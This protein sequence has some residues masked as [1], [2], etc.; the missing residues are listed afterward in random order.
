M[1]K[2]TK[3]APAKPVR[4]VTRKL[5]AERAAVRS[6]AKGGHI[7]ATRY[8]RDPE[9]VTVRLREKVATLLS[10]TSNC[11]VRAER[12]GVPDKS[13]SRL[14]AALEHLESVNSALA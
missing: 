12:N 7:P 13:I 11:V 1:N 3:K 9:A 8:S 4:K 2:K 14:R 5:V 6:A 10:V